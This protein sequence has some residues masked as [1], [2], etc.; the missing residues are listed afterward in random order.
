MAFGVGVALGAGLV[1]AVVVLVAAALA[2]WRAREV[3]E[4]EDGRS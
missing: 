1:G 4:R 3:L 2:I